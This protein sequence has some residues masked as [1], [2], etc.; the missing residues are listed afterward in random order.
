VTDSQ[1][2]NDDRDGF[3]AWASDS[4]EWLPAIERSKEGYRLMQTQQYWIAW[5]ARGS[6]ESKYWSK[7]NRYRRTLE[8]I[9]EADDCP[10]IIKAI[11]SETLNCPGKP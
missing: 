8:R 2:I 4:G 6:D 1:D 9:Q 7:S 10:S 11:I 3:E 5:K